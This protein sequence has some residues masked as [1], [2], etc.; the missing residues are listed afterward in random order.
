MCKSEKKHV[1]QVPLLGFRW[2]NSTRA[3]VFGQGWAFH[4]RDFCKLLFLRIA[5][6]EVKSKV[7]PVMQLLCA[8]EGS[9]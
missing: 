6:P 2:P 9:M 8:L 5:G 3:V 1:G 4:W 7:K